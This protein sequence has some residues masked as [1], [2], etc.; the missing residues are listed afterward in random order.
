MPSRR[1][2]TDS[3]VTHAKPGRTLTDFPGLYLNVSRTGLKSWVYRYYYQGERNEKRL[4]RLPY[5]NLRTARDRAMAMKGLLLDRIN[6]KEVQQWNE[7]H[8]KLQKTFGQV[9]DEWL[10]IQKR[11][12]SASQFYNGNNLLHVHG[13]SLS[14]LPASRITKE[15]VDKAIAPLRA[16]HPKQAKNAI[17]MWFKIFAYAEY[18]GYRTD[19]KNPARWED[20]MAIAFPSIRRVK[21]HAALNYR[22]IPAFIHKL[23][24]QGE[25]S[26]SAV[27]LEFLILTATRT[28]EVLEA[29]WDEFDDLDAPS[30]VWTIPAHRTRPRKE[31]RQPLSARA[32][33]LLKRQREYALPGVPFVFTGYGGKTPLSK[34]S[35]YRIACGESVTAHGFRSSFRTWA[36]EKGNAEWDICEMCLAHTVGNSS[37]KPYWRGDPMEKRRALMQAWCDYCQGTP[38]H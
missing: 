12:W 34:K 7:K 15:D 37:S 8:E 2:R 27:A 3:D 18:K 31:H 26:T 33:E 1:L 16:K 17:K 20:N 30:P 36:G 23:R 11:E 13:K 29:R 6:P 22:K 28:S 19:P 4:G 14:Q 38:A 5:V 9:A 24:Q 25:R 35:L 21:H 10:A 32:V